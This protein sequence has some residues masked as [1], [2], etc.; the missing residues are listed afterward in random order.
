MLMLADSIQ[1][2]STIKEACR[3]TGISRNTYYRYLSNEV[4]AEKMEKVHSNQNKV[5]FSFM[6]PFQI[7]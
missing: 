6:T 2:N 7:N 1:H 3:Y 4:F 5:V